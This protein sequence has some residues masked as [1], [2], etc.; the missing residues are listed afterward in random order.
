[1]NELLFLRGLLPTRPVR[2]VPDAAGLI[3]LARRLIFAN[4]DRAL[5]TTTGDLRRGKTSYVN[6]REHLPCLRCGTPILR[7]SLGETELSER[8]TYFCPVCQL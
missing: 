5:R 3:A 2:D 8:D 4:R 7:G 1:R 6:R